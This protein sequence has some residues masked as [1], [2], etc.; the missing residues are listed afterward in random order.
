[1]RDLNPNRQL[2]NL[3]RNMNIV[4]RIISTV[5]A[6]S[7]A[8]QTESNLQEGACFSGTLA[9]QS[10]SSSQEGSSK[11]ASISHDCFSGFG[12]T[13]SL[14]LPPVLGCG[15]SEASCKQKSNVRLAEAMKPAQKNCRN[16]P[17]LSSSEISS[18]SK[19]TDVTICDS[20]SSLFK[21]RQS[22]SEDHENH[23]SSSKVITLSSR[24][25][26]TCRP[27]NNNMVM[28]DIDLSRE[29]LDKAIIKQKLRKA[30]EIATRLNTAMSESN[31]KTPSKYCEKPRSSVSAPSKYSEE[32]HSSVS[33][34]SSPAEISFFEVS[35]P[36]KRHCGMSLGMC[37][38]H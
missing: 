34:M 13:D 33:N 6:K 5:D 32:P 21:K 14:D 30:A 2:N 11:T 28:V 31:S 38:L 4:K 24:S 17:S 36:R 16:A 37:S 22:S 8:A 26:R 27:R 9:A 12:L 20:E 25:S 3:L 1:M 10:E 23:A 35:P 18:T 15:V 19:T 7:L 29:V